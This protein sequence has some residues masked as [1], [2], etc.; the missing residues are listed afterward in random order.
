MKLLSEEIDF[1]KF[2]LQYAGKP[3]NIRR[4]AMQQL[5]QKRNLNIEKNRNAMSKKMRGKYA[6]K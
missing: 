6:N 3:A 5:Q 1:K 2:N 4:R